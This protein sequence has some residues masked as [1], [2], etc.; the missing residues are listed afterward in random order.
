MPSE[1]GDLRKL[2]H[3]M[4][5]TG[6][7]ALDVPALAGASNGALSS[8]VALWRTVTDR[9]SVRNDCLIGFIDRRV[10]GATGHDQS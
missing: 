5:R 7:D 10:A 2:C 6:P 9:P 8:P 1:P 3:H 4:N